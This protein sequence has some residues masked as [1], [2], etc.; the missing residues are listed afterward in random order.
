MTGPADAVLHE[1]GIGDL[2]AVTL[3][4]ILQLRTDVFV[5]EQACAY[6]ELDGR[7]LD[8]STI[9]LW[10]EA[11]GRPLSYLRVLSEP[12]AAK[13]GRVVTAADSRRQGLGAALVRAALAR[14]SGSVVL[15]AQS[16]LQSWYEQLGF[17]VDGP[18]FVE[19][20]IEHVPM[21][22]TRR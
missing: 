16:H 9:H 22:L 2:D 10:F 15:D 13:I 3:Y 1:S 12:G 6:P 5:V 20:G 18:E 7:D 8:H 11:G 14:V 21:R 17:A 19:D 4:R